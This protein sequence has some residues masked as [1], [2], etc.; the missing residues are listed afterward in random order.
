M[1]LMLMTIAM[2]VGAV[3]FFTK[4]RKIDLEFQAEPKHDEMMSSDDERWL[5]AGA[6]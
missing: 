3:Y 6:E 1:K 2:G 4:N 5:A